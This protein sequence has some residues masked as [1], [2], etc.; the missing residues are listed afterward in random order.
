MD[1]DIVQLLPTSAIDIQDNPTIVHVGHYGR[2]TVTLMP[3]KTTKIPLRF[4]QSTTMEKNL[5]ASS[6]K[7]L[8]LSKPSLPKGWVYEPEEVRTEVKV[9]VVNPAQYQMLDALLTRSKRKA[10]APLDDPHLQSPPASNI[11]E[12][13]H[14]SHSVSATNTAVKR[15]RITS[16]LT[17]TPQ[18]P[19]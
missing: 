17:S 15:W 3:L 12:A 5:H 4:H 19:L 7:G 6:Q 11:T 9:E 10:L 1:F 14:L 8:G 2:P 16:V 18:T 13:R